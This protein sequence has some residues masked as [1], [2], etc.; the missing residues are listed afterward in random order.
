MSCDFKHRTNKW[1][2][3]FNKILFPL[4]IKCHIASQSVIL[5]LFWLYQMDT[6]S[7]YRQNYKMAINFTALT[8]LITKRNYFIV[9]QCVHTWDMHP[10]CF[11]SSFISKNLIQI[12]CIYSILQRQMTQNN[13][14]LQFIV[15]LLIKSGT[16]IYCHLNCA[17]EHIRTH[18]YTYICIQIEY[19]LINM[20]THKMNQWTGFSQFNI[21]PLIAQ[22]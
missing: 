18:A 19:A 7:C 13:I 22:V 5:S 16:F 20:K 11:F 6:Q 2:D 12:K 21:F 1:L 9:I 4:K 17:H 10:L 3:L 14:D 15:H 8:L